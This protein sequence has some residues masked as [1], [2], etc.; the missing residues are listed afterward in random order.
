MSA[1]A[2]LLLALSF[3]PSDAKS[4]PW[5][6]SNPGWE[7][8]GGPGRGDI[9]RRYPGFLFRVVFGYMIQTR[10]LCFDGGFGLRADSTESF[11]G[12]RMER[13]LKQIRQ[14]EDS[15]WRWDA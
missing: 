11:E 8:D 7:W 2:V 14:I 4:F 13:R 12:N 15:Q 1:V 5:T 3:L 9:F 6:P 10:V